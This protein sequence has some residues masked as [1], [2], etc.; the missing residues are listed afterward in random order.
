MAIFSLKSD[1][2]Q[3]EL[4]LG[5]LPIDSVE[6]KPFS[7]LASMTRS[8]F[9]SSSENRLQL[10]P[11]GTSDN[12][13]FIEIFARGASRPIGDFTFRV[14][15]ILDD[16]AQGKLVDDDAQVEVGAYINI[17]RRTLEEHSKRFA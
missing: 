13:G 3:I 7:D 15:A 6:G 10:D 14:S 1:L 2:M 9:L 5:N 11:P 12:D 17:L 8:I 4:K 16:I